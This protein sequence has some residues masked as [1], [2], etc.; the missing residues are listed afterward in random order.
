[1]GAVRQLYD[2]SNIISFKE[3]KGGKYNRTKNEAPG[4]ETENR[5]VFPIEDKQDV[6]RVI[7]YLHDK[8]ISAKRADTRRSAY[9]NWLLFIIGINVGVRVS[10]LV[11]LKWEDFF[12]NDM[13]T[14]VDSVNIIEKKTG[15]TKDIC[16]NNT[17][18]RAI[19]E[20]LSVIDTELKPSNYLF[21]SGR[22]DENGKYTQ[23]TDAAVEKMMKDVAKGCHLKG[24]YNT[25]S[26]RKTYAYHKYM[27]YVENG[28]TMALV[29]VQKDLN[30]R[31]SSDTA[32]YLGITRKEKIESSM[33]L[34]DYWDM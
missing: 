19:K 16:P 22:K 4:I 20:Y 25:H 15:K 7:T 8:A 29:K 33:E 31:N 13:K 34:S 1:M 30:H 18:K 10:D 17:V 21:L 12:E 5:W 11:E 2:D 9:R 26:I 3:I 27:M 14:F 6:K 28:D 32:R 23:I 24:N